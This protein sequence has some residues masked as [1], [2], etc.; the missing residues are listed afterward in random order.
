MIVR[1]HRRHGVFLVSQLITSDAHLAIG[2]DET[3][4]RNPD[5]EAVCSNHIDDL[6]CR[7][8][9]QLT[10]DLCLYYSISR[11]LA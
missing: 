7:A 5:I 9:E 11:R 10:I 3:V 6:A 2:L 1:E 8:H 4:I